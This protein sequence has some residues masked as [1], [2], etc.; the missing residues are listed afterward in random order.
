MKKK[1]IALLLT[2]AL[3]VTVLAGCSASTPATA[4]KEAAPAAE[5]KNFKVGITIQ[6][7]ENSY[8]AG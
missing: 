7:L 3:I 4:E 5:T 2:L 8:W 6:S 1:M